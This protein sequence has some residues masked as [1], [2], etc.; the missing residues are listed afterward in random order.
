MCPPPEFEARESA[1]ALLAELSEVPPRAGYFTQAF[2]R[3]AR[4]IQPDNGAR[5]DAIRDAI[6]A[7][8]DPRALPERS[9]DVSFWV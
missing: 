1:E 5:V 8:D 3:D 9:V 4:Y 7:G 6:A 2:C